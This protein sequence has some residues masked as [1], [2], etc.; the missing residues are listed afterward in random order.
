MNVCY[1]ESEI[2]NVHSENL[3]C[4]END[5][6]V[7]N[8]KF[9]TRSPQHSLLANRSVIYIIHG[10]PPAL[11]RNLQLHHS[12][13]WLDLLLSV[14]LQHIGGP[15]YHTLLPIGRN[16]LSW[17]KTFFLLS[18]CMTRMPEEVAGKK[19]TPKML[20]IWWEHTELAVTLASLK[21]STLC[22]LCGRTEKPGFVSSG[23]AKWN[24]IMWTAGAK[25]RL[26]MQL[27]NVNTHQ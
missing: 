26:W 18:W 24:R 13:T 12:S 6:G 7:N 16:L 15:V 19:K 25:P 14:A 11:R 1:K 22:T 10:P 5:K 20:D 9:M 2:I 4:C 21:T 3:A 17:K 8:V 27:S 23:T